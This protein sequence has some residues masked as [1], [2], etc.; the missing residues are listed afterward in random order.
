[1]IMDNNK[2]LKAI[3]ICTVLLFVKK[4]N[5]EANDTNRDIF[6]LLFSDIHYNWDEYSSMNFNIKL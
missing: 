4:Y 6:Y 1:M 5:I 2:L 3:I